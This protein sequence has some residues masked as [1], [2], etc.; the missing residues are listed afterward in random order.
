MCLFYNKVIYFEGVTPISPSDSSTAPG[1]TL[2]VDLRMKI[3]AVGPD[4]KVKVRFTEIILYFEIIC[5]FPLASNLGYCWSG[6]IPRN[7]SSILSDG[8]CRSYCI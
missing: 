5:L 6:T 3:I 1:A 7:I 2:G 8:S 4:E